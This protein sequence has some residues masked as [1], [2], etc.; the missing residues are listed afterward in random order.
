M[1]NCALASE[2]V[3]RRDQQFL[4]LAN[5]T[6]VGSITVYWKSIAVR[7]LFNTKLLILYWAL[8]TIFAKIWWVN[9]YSKVLKAEL[10][11]WPLNL[12]FKKLFQARTW[13]LSW[14][15]KI[16]IP[17]S[18]VKKAWKS[19]N[20]NRVLVGCQKLES[21]RIRNQKRSK[22]SEIVYI[23]RCLKINEVAIGK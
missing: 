5:A 2:S 3:F 4:Y 22:R 10:K 23:T 6:I 21:L 7:A 19:K 15:I 18:R 13:N 12:R 14:K 16:S 8:W 9:G 1:A 11:V 20:R 17:L